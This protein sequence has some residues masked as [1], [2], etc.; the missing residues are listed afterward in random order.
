MV[1]KQ[2]H[3]LVLAFFL[4]QHKLTL[5]SGHHVKTGHAT[6]SDDGLGTGHAFSFRIVGPHCK[7]EL[8]EASPHSTLAL[9]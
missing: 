8:L 2:T 1:T 9:T 4:T 6:R 5:T 7:A 3:L